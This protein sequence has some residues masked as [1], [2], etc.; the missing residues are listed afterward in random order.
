VLHEVQRKCFVSFCGGGDFFQK[1]TLGHSKIKL[2]FFLEC[3]TL[4]CFM[5]TEYYLLVVLKQCCIE[6][7]AQPQNFEVRAMNIN[8]GLKRVAAKAA[9]SATVPTAL[10]ICEFTT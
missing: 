5:H 3:I 6:E 10:C 2:L 4:P 9:T 8:I 7:T 1:H